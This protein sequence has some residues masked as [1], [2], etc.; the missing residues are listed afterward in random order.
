MLKQSSVVAT[1]QPTQKY[2]IATD[3]NRLYLRNGFYYF[4]TRVPSDLKSA[5]PHPYTGKREIKISLKTK[6]RVQALSLFSLHASCIDQIFASTRL[7]LLTGVQL[8]AHP[9]TTKNYPQISAQAEP[10]QDTVVTP[11]DICITFD[12]LAQQRAEQMRIDRRAEKSIEEFQSKMKVFSELFRDRL[13]SRFQEDLSAIQYDDI[14]AVLS[15]LQN[16]QRNGR[17][18][19]PRTA[20]A[21]GIA[22]ASLFKFG[23]QQRYLSHSCMPKLVKPK[24]MKC[25]AAGGQAGWKSLGEAELHKLLMVLSEKTI[26]TDTK[27]HQ[28]DNELSCPD[29]FLRIRTMLALYS[30][31]RIEEICSLRC[32]DIQEYDGVPCISVNA[33]YGKHVKS[34]SSLR[35]VPLHPSISERVLLHRDQMLQGY[36][37]T[38]VS[39]Q[40]LW[41]DVKPY[42]GKYSAAF[43]KKFGR[44]LRKYVSQ[45][46]MHVFHSL[47]KNFAQGLQHEG[48]QRELISDLLGH[49]D[50][51]VTS[52]YT[53]GYS[54]QAK[55]EAIQ[56]L[57]F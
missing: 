33:L 40:L 48:A 27:I 16:Y 47:R 35:I 36:D 19:G 54:I 53:G 11:P 17:T 8:Q 13:G 29:D 55:V 9:Q 25:S 31:L 15:K 45:D 21:Y 44:F 14:A 23:V 30:G 52:L 1:K 38:V 37:S 20:Y 46:K 57:K 6:N 50:P 51:T 5:L 26:K 32:K 10:A 34:T 49:S 24:E 28:A 43:S 39:D 42:R 2:L 56:L 22:L 41:P 18:I 4:R 7:R 12:S 3:I